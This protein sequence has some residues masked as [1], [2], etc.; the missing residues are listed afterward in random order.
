MTGSP[1][2][3]K[4]RP[5]VSDAALAACVHERYGLE[6]GTIEFLPVGYD[7]DSWVYRVTASDD[8]DYF[9][10]LKRRIE[11]PA[12]LRVPYYLREH[13]ITQV[14]A[15]LAATSGK[16]W[17]QMDDFA[18]ILYPFVT[19]ASGVDTGLTLAQWAEFGAILRGVHEISLPDDL[20]RRLPREEFRPD[21]DS[22]ASALAIASGDQNTPAD[23]I[24]TELTTFLGDKR[25]LVAR[26]VSRCDEL[27]DRLRRRRWDLVL[28]HADAHLANILV[29]SSGHV[30][31]VDWDQPIYAPIERDLMVVCSRALNGFAAG[32]PQETAF[33]DGYGPVAVDPIAL[34]Y[35][36]YAWAVED[37]GS[38]A[39]EILRPFD[40]ND[41]S[42]RRA[43]NALRGVFGPGGMVEEA[44]RSEQNIR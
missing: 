7:A 3:A 19:G 18:L 41:S 39:T 26:V 35:Y 38:F 10:K 17:S 44:L 15:P 12:M 5:R 13:G 16:L 2:G 34:A 28:C 27:G 1:S 40:S 36:R 29:D 4:I 32:S 43:L 25:D 31:I 11:Q 24:S 30:F 21:L 42:R 20:G 23:A 8:T 33:F 22:R 9:L 6:P 37:I 14:V